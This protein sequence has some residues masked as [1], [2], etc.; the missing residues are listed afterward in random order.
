MSERE[1]IKLVEEPKQG[2]TTEVKHLDAN[3]L[4]VVA[5]GVTAIAESQ[6]AGRIIREIVDK[7]KALLNTAKK[8]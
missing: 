7:G 5:A 2:N 4:L 6:K 8:E 1:T 3:T